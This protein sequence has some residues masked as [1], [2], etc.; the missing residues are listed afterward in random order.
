M[1]DKSENS[2]EDK[3]AGFLKAYAGVPAQLRSEII[4]LI[5]DK[6]YNWDSAYFEVKNDTELGKK[7]LNTLRE[8]GII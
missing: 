3:K 8:I 4:V 5:E 1:E 2:K 6:P 7:I